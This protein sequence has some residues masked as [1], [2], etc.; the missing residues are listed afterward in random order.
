MIRVL[1]GLHRDFPRRGFRP[2][3][4]QD[5]T[6][7]AFTLLEML[8]IGVFLGILAAIAAPS[9]LHFFDNLAL[10]TARSTLYQALQTTRNT[11]ALKSRNWRMSFRTQANRMQWATH[12]ADVTPQE[13]DWNALDPAIALSNQTTLDQSNAMYSVQFNHKGHTSDLG[14]ITLV[15]KRNPNNQRCVVISTLLGN[16]RQG[17]GNPCN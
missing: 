9:W 3:R 2:H 16:M 12:Q 5:L 1:L 6:Q 10:N 7:P 4:R 11:A 17:Q 8:V 15:S 14:R 13:S